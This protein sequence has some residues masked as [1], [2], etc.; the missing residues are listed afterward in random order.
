[1]MIPQLITQFTLTKTGIV[2]SSPKEANCS[3]P[4]SSVF[5]QYAYPYLSEIYERLPSSCCGAARSG[6]LDEKCYASVKE[7]VRNLYHLVRKCENPKTMRDKHRPG[8][9]VSCEDWVGCG[10]ELTP[11]KQFPMEVRLRA[12][13]SKPQRNRSQPPPSQLGL[14][15]SQLFY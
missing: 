13:H 4:E 5:Q 3:L 14:E 9:I 10:R 1:M 11:K 15:P 2:A 12:F 7:A 6:L 8:M